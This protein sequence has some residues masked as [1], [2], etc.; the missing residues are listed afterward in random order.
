MKKLSVTTT[1]HERLWG[2]IYLALQLLILPSLLVLCNL[3][4]H[5]QLT[6][7][8]INFLFFALNFICVTVIFHRFLLDNGKNALRAPLFVMAT[9]IGGYFL[10]TFFSSVV[11]IL[12][13]GLYPDFFNVNDSYISTM[14]ADDF[15]LM[16]VGTVFLVPITEESLYRGLI[17]GSL[18]NRS[19]VLAYAVS[20]LAFAALHVISYIGA[21]SPIHLLF[22]LLEYIPAG[23]ILGWAYARTDSLWTPILIHTL[24]NG[25]AVSVM[26]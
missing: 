22:C 24:V 7:S 21:Y 12:I 1:F 18:Y 11:S 4:F 26:R 25:I 6:D 19:R 17:F 16:I 15:K 5:L 10:Y 23:L 2:L 3:L 9:T 14:V 13:Q 20:T 8:K